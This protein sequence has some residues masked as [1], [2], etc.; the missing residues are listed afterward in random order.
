MQVV[1][2]DSDLPLWQVPRDVYR[3]AIASRAE[4]LHRLAT[5]GELGAHLVAAIAR[6]VEVLDRAGVLLGETFI[7]GDNPLVLLTALASSFH[8]DPSSSPSV[9]RPCP[10]VLDAGAYE[11]R[12]DGRPIRTFT[13]IDGRLMFADLYAKL[14]AHAAR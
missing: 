3:M 1:F 14:A 9:V 10:R 6:I 11:Q 13:G 7:L 8:A 12:A 4:L 2:D 5:A